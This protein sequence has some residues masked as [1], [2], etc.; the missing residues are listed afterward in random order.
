MP[1]VKALYILEK[2]GVKSSIKLIN[3]YFYDYMR[4]HLLSIAC[5]LSGEEI[6]IGKESCLKILKYGKAD[7]LHNIEIYRKM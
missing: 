7:D 1:L 5:L 6:E 2:P 3:H 4:Y